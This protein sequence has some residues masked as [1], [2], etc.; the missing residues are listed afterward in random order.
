MKVYYLY[1]V[2]LFSQF[3]FSQT[4]DIIYLWPNKVPNETE[5]KSRPI[6]TP[7][8]SRGVIR[9]TNITNPSLTAFRPSKSQNNKSAI[10]IAPGGGYSYLAINI[11]GYE[12]AEWLNTLG[13][14]AFVL[15]YRAPNNRLG[16]LNDMQRAIKIVRN[17]SDKYGVDSDKIGVMGFSA[18]GNLAL[19]AATNYRDNSYPSLDSID[20]ESSRPD[21]SI[22]MYPGYRNDEKDIQFHEQMP[23]VFLYGTFDDFL[24]DGL[25]NLGKALKA[26]NAKVEMHLYETG[27]HGYG[28]R[29]GN[30][31]AEKWPLLFEVWIEKVLNNSEN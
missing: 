1:T 23:P 7:D 8:T 2:L 14:T 6:H 26:T 25:L 19:K 11:E 29:K 31:A 5:I 22:L 13:F 17:L 24:I 18:G 30:D 27:G 16:A 21:F 4:K 20:S 12:I 28:M 10:I 15:E 9:I 3:V